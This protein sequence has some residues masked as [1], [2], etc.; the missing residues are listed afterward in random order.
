[1]TNSNNLYRLFDVYTAEHDISSRIDVERIGNALFLSEG[2]PSQVGHGPSGFGVGYKKNVCTFERN[3]EE[4]MHHYQVQQVIFGDV[5]LVTQ[6]Q[7]DGYSCKCGHP[8]V[9]PARSTPAAATANPFGLLTVEENTQ[10]PYHYD[11]HED[12]SHDTDVRARQRLGIAPIPLQCLVEISTS[13]ITSHASDVP[14]PKMYFS[15][16]RQHFSAKYQRG[17]GIADADAYFNRPQ[18]PPEPQRMVSE[19]WSWQGRNQEGL[20]F[21]AGILRGLIEAA[22]E[23]QRTRGISKTALVVQNTGGRVSAYLYRRADDGS[24]ALPEDLH[25]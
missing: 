5:Q 3:L 2:Q 7:V 21:V 15:G 11:E 6:T 10:L 14:F 25:P 19:L 20:R 4:S 17:M 1:M 24:S 18:V 8:P 13:N 16:I 23:T 12:L 22:D 9:P